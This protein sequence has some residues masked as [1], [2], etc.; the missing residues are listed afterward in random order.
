LSHD[1]ITNMNAVNAAAIVINVL[2]IINSIK[3]LIY[4]INI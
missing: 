3:E 2:F 1:A 4:F